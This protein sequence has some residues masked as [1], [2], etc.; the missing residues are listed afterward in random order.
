MQQQRQAVL[1]YIAMQE[2]ERMRKLHEELLVKMQPNG[3]YIRTNSPQVPYAQL[4][5]PRKD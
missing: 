2:A 4:H 1:H 3:T 5:P